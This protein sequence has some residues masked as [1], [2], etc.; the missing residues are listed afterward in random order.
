MHFA[1]FIVCQGVLLQP[2][3]NYLVRDLHRFA[4]FST[5][6]EV[7]DIQ[8]FACISPTVTQQSSRLSESDVAFLQFNIFRYRT[9]KE[10]Q[11]VVF[12]Q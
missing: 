2:F 6:D 11:E 1:P 9:V 10:L 7:K 8:Q 5:D 12:L 3:F 4:S